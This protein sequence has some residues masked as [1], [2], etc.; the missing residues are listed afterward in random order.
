[1][2]PTSRLR[3]SLSKTDAPFFQDTAV[4]PALVRHW[5]P[6]SERPRAGELL[7]RRATSPVP[8]GVRTCRRACADGQDGPQLPP[9]A[10]ALSD[11]RFALLESYIKD[12]LDLRVPTTELAAVVGLSHSYFHRAFVLRTGTTPHSWMME[13]RL[14]FARELMATVHS[15]LATIA[16]QC[17]FCD[18]AHM[19]NTFR[20]VYGMAPT[21][22]R[23]SHATPPLR[24]HA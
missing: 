14:K 22:W 1:M 2:L 11:A 7:F 23:G 24:R 18:Q 3:G 10:L 9:R 20:R 19:T 15:S 8:R 4:N 16:A 13:L 12:R 17:G 6:L 21:Q 5:W